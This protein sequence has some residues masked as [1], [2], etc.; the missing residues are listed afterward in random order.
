[1]NRNVLVAILVFLVAYAVGLWFKFNDQ[2]DIM[3]TVVQ[4]DAGEGA[5]ELSDPV[6]LAME[7]DVPQKVTPLLDT[8]GS[9]LQEVERLEPADLPQ[10]VSET[11][12]G[13]Y[14]QT[15]EWN[16][17]P[18]E[19]VDSQT[20]EPQG[21]LAI[22]GR[23]LNRA[24]SPVPGI[25]VIAKASYLFDRDKGKLTPVYK[26]QLAA[27]SGYDGTYAFERL[28]DGEY[29][30]STE[31]TEE[32][33]RAQISVRAGVDFADLV[34]TGQ[35]QL[36]VHGFVSTADGELLA[37]VVV[38]PVTQSA[39]TVSS[40]KEG[41]YAFEMKLMDTAQGL[42]V[43]A[44]KK[45]YEDKEVQLDTSQ[46]DA[47]D[48]LELNIVMEPDADS[49]LAEVSGRVKG[50]GNDP[51]AG[52][53]IG[54]LSSKARQN[55]RAITDADG[56]FVIRRVEPGDDYMLSIN[57]VAAYKDYFQRDIKVTKNGLTL[58]IGLE[59][60]DTGTLSGQMLNVFGAPI[61]NF[62]LVLQTKETSYYNQRVLGDAA[63]NFTVEKTPAGELRLKTKSTPYYT[64]E[65][66]LLN[67]GAELQVPVI[68]DWGYD[69]IHGRVVN[70]QG[71][72]VAVTNV[73]L[74]WSHEQYGIRS[75][76]RRTTS[77]DEQGNFRFTQL[78]PGHHR[79]TVNATGY[80]LVDV[81]HDVALQGSELVVKLEAK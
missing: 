42:A 46:P 54:L 3:T 19:A 34:L 48:N 1:M 14:E 75:S 69:E 77:A 10:R 23:V 24:G 78:G 72:P 22:S 70:E 81:D 44:S 27:T 8:I 30:I 35:R 12:I 37:G 59:A 36:R 43:R 2:Q 6:V 16:D 25:R 33:S 52:Q 73:S 64:I 62:T 29:R 45:G 53:H 47:G 26:Y 80:R 60:L 49:V 38:T 41:R 21:D 9:G 58:S 7:P 28:A 17:T 11:T 13:V 74:T 20:T 68:L 18:E 39:T 51:V 57:A 79:L 5:L 65:G 32:Y 71:Y 66:I 76:S 61:P 55:Y 50:P 67:A 40:S 56:R 63:G 15:D 31:A 4:D